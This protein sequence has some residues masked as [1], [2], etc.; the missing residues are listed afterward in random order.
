M[1]HLYDGVNGDVLEGHC[2]CCDYYQYVV[3]KASK[4]PRGT[5]LA[6]VVNVPWTCSSCSVE[7]TAVSDGDRYTNG[8]GSERSPSYKE[9]PLPRVYSSTE[10]C[11]HCGEQKKIGFM[12]CSHCRLDWLGRSPEQR[13]RY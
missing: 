8:P 2:P 11:V 1:K 5:N 12:Y 9:P 4:F 7:F 6:K 10:T 13:V 3:I